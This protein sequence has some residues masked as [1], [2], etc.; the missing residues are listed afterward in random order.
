[1]LHSSLQFFEY[2]VSSAGKLVALVSNFVPDSLRPED[3]EF[4]T[5]LWLG[6]TDLVL[7][8]SLT[9]SARPRLLIW[10][11]V[12]M[13]RQ[14]HLA[15]Y[16]YLN[17]SGKLQFFTACNI[18]SS[19][20]SCDD[21]RICVFTEVLVWLRST[22][23]ACFKLFRDTRGNVSETWKSPVLGNSDSVL[24]VGLTS[25]LI[26]LIGELSCRGLDYW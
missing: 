1:M 12:N 22:Y 24:V 8:A 6:T 10:V 25:S 5:A 4:I 14:C 26:S 17:S 3:P 16:G 9:A 11:V 2:R 15:I 13:W 18:A 23:R 21:R 7:S 20:F 19:E